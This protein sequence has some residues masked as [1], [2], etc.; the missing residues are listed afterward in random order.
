[1]NRDKTKYPIF[2]ISKGR[3][4][5]HFTA[6]TLDKMNVEYRIV[7]E[8]KEFPQYSAVIEE[9]NIIVAPENFSER[10]EG[11]IPVRNFVFETAIREGH[12]KHWILDDNIR[13]IGMANKNCRTPC[14]NI[15]PF[16]VCED[17]TDRF[18]N[19]ALSGMN[20]TM[21]FIPQSPP[22]P[23]YFSMQTKGGRDT[24]ASVSKKIDILKKAIDKIT[25]GDK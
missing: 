12:K 18:K 15:K 19:I 16:L 17:F 13:Y 4:D 6:K 20:Y 24:Q 8:P 5:S 21:F 9:S 22:P 3:W 11:G 2:I 1:M 10:G 14:R 23:F 7:V 25:A